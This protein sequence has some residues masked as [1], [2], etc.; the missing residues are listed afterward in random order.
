MVVYRSFPEK[1]LRDTYTPQRL[2]LQIAAAA[3]MLAALTVIVFQPATGLTVFLVSAG[4]FL[5]TALS[6]LQIAFAHDRAVGW[7][8]VPLLV[9]RAVA[10][11]AGITYFLVIGTRKLR[12][13]ESA[14]H[15]PRPAAASSS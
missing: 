2:K 5:A 8:S 9:C 12:P 10:I 14:S 3:V 11:G 7:M 1:M 15:S 6:F 13:R 4:A